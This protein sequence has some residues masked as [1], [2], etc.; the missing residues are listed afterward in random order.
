MNFKQIIE[1]YFTFS[2]NERKGITILLVVI[3]MLA[4]A[5]KIIYY[6]ET[7]AI[8]DTHLLD[9]PNEPGLIKDTKNNLVQQNKLFNFNDCVVN[10]VDTSTQSLT[11]ALSKYV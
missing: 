1:D 4:V 6:F 9:S 11:I 10:L 7:P 5:N 3:F 2:R 8:I